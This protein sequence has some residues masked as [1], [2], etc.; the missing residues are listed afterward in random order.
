MYQHTEITPTPPA[1]LLLTLREA[2]QVLSLGERKIR[3][4][5]SS[6]ELPCVRIG[7]ALR[8]SHEALREWVSQRSTAVVSCTPAE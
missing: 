8:F 6:G 4:M 5:V 2:Q 3:D 7:R 1:K